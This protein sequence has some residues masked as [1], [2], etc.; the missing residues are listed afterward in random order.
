MEQKGGS[1]Q[2]VSEEDEV[3]RVGGEQD[4]AGVLYVSQDGVGRGI[5]R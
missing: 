3:G 5:G 1:L 4:V 2:V